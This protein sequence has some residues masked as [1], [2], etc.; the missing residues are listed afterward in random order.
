M[1]RLGHVMNGHFMM[2]GYAHVI[3][4]AYHVMN[5]LTFP[6]LMIRVTSGTLHQG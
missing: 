5:N 4:G 2:D 1:N 3:D 6:R